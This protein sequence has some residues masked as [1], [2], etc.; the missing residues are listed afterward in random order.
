V[1][2]LL[3]AGAD[4][5]IR[6][7][8]QQCKSGYCCCMGISQASRVPGRS[9]RPTF[10]GSIA[11]GEILR[12]SQWQWID[13]DQPATMQEFDAARK[14]EKEAIA[15]GGPALIVLP[16]VPNSGLRR[17]TQPNVNTLS[18]ISKAKDTDAVTSNGTVASIAGDSKE[19]IDEFGD[20]SVDPAV[21]PAKTRAGSNKK[22]NLVD[23]LK[24]L[25]MVERDIETEIEKGRQNDR[26]GQTGKIRLMDTLRKL[27]MTK[28]VSACASYIILRG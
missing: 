1:K 7:V 22:A 21:E 13:V 28:E 3:N 6:A 26:T 23:A 19:H 24:K 12:N 18:D 17:N 10:G 20:G 16:D 8:D 14:S 11:V 4:P 5:T 2:L 25:G 27:G 9:G 15:A